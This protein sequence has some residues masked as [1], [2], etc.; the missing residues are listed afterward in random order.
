M[1]R[2]CAY[3]HNLQ[4]AHRVGCREKK[5]GMDEGSGV[6][7]ITGEW[8]YFASFGIVLLLLLLTLLC[9]TFTSLCVVLRRLRL[10]ELASPLSIC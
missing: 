7:T 1:K 10:V 5:T 9:V 6:V 8:Y 3:A 4:C 2:A